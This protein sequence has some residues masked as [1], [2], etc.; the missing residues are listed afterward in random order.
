MK[1]CF[2]AFT[3][4]LAA[5]QVNAEATLNDGVYTKDQ[6]ATTGK[7][8]YEKNCKACHNAEFYKEKFQSWNQAPLIEF[9]DL[10]SATM[11]QNAPGSLALQEYTDAL[12]YIFYMLDYPAGD[13][14]LS[15][16]D[17]SMED[18]LIVT[19]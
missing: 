14:A 11:P 19:D 9:Y 2:T 8:S 7:A 10:V 3:L 4:L 18:I 16:E 1:F 15:H 5:A 13:K 12:A 6:A 17:G